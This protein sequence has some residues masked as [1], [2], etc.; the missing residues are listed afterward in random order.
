VAVLKN[1][2]V[3]KTLDQASQQ[4]RVQV[5]DSDFFDLS[6]NAAPAAASPSLERRSP[7]QPKPASPAVNK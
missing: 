5:Q 4:Y 7:G 6:S 1:N 2:E 3:K